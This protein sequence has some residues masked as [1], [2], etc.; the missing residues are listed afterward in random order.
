MGT[1]LKHAF[2]SVILLQTNMTQR[3]DLLSIQ[4]LSDKCP[5]SSP[6]SR[7]SYFIQNLLN[8]SGRSVTKKLK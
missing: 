3:S 7:H 5:T 2:A 4:I 1:P 8:F 6:Q